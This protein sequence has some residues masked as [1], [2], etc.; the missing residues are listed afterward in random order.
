MK[1]RTKLSAL[2]LAGC[3]TVS[4]V[5]M[6]SAAGDGDSLNSYEDYVLTQRTNYAED[7]T[8]ST[9]TS[10]YNSHGD[11][12]SEISSNPSAEKR[13][14]EFTYDAKGNITNQKE[15]VN[16]VLVTE[17]RR[18]FDGRDVISDTHGS[19]KNGWYKTTYVYDDNTITATEYGTD[20]KKVSDTVSTYNDYGD[21]VKQVTT[22]ADGTVSYTRECTYDTDGNLTADNYYQLIQGHKRIDNHSY[23]YN[24]DGLC[25]K[26][27][28]V[29]TLDGAELSNESYTK[30]ISYTMNADG[31]VASSTAVSSDGNTYRYEYTADSFKYYYNDK[32]SEFATY[33]E[34]YNTTAAYFAFDENG[35]PIKDKNC[36]YYEYS[37]LADLLKGEVS[38]SF[39][40]VKTDEYYATPILWAVNNGITNGMGNNQFIPNMNCTR[41]QI[42]TFLYR[43]AGEPEVTAS[44]TFSDVDSSAYYAKAV[45]WAVENEITNGMGD[46]KF[47]PESTCTRGQTVTFIW[48]ASGKPEA[49]ASNSFTDVNS[50]AYYG[51]AVAWAVEN[52]VTNGMGNNK[53][54]PD[55]TCTRGHIVTFLYRA[56]AY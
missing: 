46:N 32:L 20:G 17:S 19:D 12:I 21:Y 36:T 26:E 37:K 31:T 33:D 48:R 15:L 3:M 27:I 11:L 2:L 44:N 7:G 47:E 51:Q 55:T 43:M 4:L 41:G 45:A 49:S 40:D 24:A 1:L 9:I 14:T 8:K 6:A 30:D 34:N 29:S 54:E 56:F 23:T 13:T 10:S 18:E 38:K 42:V 35:N 53:F 22:L 25:T 50:K 16:D 5:P 52:E 28:H 39:T